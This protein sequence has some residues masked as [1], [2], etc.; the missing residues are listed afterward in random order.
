LNIQCGFHIFLLFEKKKSKIK[1]IIISDKATKVIM[2]TMFFF[3]GKRISRRKIFNE[4]NNVILKNV[5]HT[6]DDEKIEVFKNPHLHSL[7]II[8][9]ICQLS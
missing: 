8:P 7:Q 1:K 9:M 4:S 3:F 5:V 2:Y 6:I